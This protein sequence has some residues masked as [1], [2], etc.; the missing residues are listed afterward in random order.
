VADYY[1]T[2]G[3]EKTASTDE[4]KKSY[5]KLAL[6]FHPD[7]NKGNKEAEEKFKEISE[8]YAVL[9]DDEKRKQYDSFGDSS[10]HQR[11]SQEDIFRNTD[12]GTVFQEFDLGGF[13]DIFGRM[14][15]GGGG[16][17]GGGFEGINFGAGRQGGRG[18]FRGAAAK[19]QDVEYPVQISFDEAFR[20]SERQ[21]AFQLA[22]AAARNLKV[23]VPAGV[24]DGGRL[25]VAGMGAPSPL[26]GPAGDLFVVLQVAPHPQFMR[27]GEDIEI[28]MPLKISEAV[29]GTSREVET[30]DGVKKVKIPSGV[31]T[32]TK[33]RLKGLGFPIPGKSSRG[34]FYVVV[35]VTI[36]HN[37][38]Q[39]QKKAVEALQSVDL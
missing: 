28:K 4:I 3:V 2:L 16:F 32:G 39:A 29:L 10:F 36:P 25:R 6:K 8:A 33:V 23:R 5:R 24:K 37:L 9:A 34:D 27:V 17:S 7:R 21:I 31:K 38:T 30:L 20:G 11:Y 14:F 35:D 13:G 18:G 12:F 1:K 15:S 19:G 26:G 22:G